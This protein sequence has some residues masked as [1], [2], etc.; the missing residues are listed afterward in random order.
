MKKTLY[1]EFCDYIFDD[2]YGDYNDGWSDYSQF[3]CDYCGFYGKKDYLKF[4][5]D[6]IDENKFAKKHKMTKEQSE[7]LHTSEPLWSLVDSKYY[8]ITENI[9][10]GNYWGATGYIYSK[11]HPKEFKEFMVQQPEPTDDVDIFAEE[12]IGWLK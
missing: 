2:G 3:I 4:C 12:N 10:L 11:H 5:H 8:S 7:W 9:Y 1:E 6:I